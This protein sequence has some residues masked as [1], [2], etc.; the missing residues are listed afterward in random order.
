MSLQHITWFEPPP[1]SADVPSGLPDLFADDAFRQP[2]HPLAQRAAAM[3]IAELAPATLAALQQPGGGKMFGVLLVCDLSATPR[4]GFLRGFSGKLDGE[5]HA[6]GYVPPLFDEAARALWWTDG[7]AYLATLDAQLAALEASAAYID[8]A[9]TL[10]AALTAQTAELEQ[11]RAM[12]LARRNQRAEQRAATP[13]DATML[14]QLDAA[15]RRDGALQRETKQRLASAVQQARSALQPLTAEHTRLRELRSATSRRFMQTVY[16]EYDLRGVDNVRVLLRDCFAPHDPPGGAGD[17][18]APKMVGFANAHGLRSLA[19]A[20]FWIGSPPTHGGRVHGVFYPPCRGKCGAILPKMLPAPIATPIAMPITQVIAT[21]PLLESAAPAL[22]SLA[23]IPVLYRDDRLLIV[24]KPSGMLSIPGRGP[25]LADA[26]QTR[27]QQALNNPAAVVAHRLDQDT[28]G[29]IVVA[30]DAATL[31]AMHQLF[32][33]RD[34][35][36]HYIAEL[37]GTTA[38]LP[39]GASGTIHLPL[40]PDHYDRPRQIVDDELGKSAATEWCVLQVFANR[41]RVQLTP[42]TG[43][44]HQL[45]VHAAHPKGLALPIAG[46][47]IYGHGPTPAAPRLLLHAARL[48]FVHPWTGVVIELASPVPF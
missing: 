44:T 7:E 27:A 23:D 34:V 3:V 39:A 45:R 16:D 48:R 9:A 35:V 8:A 47:R 29:L 46:D 42:Q 14:Q 43:R 22:S 1:A 13:D 26:V 21:Q 38:A 28:S 36:K 17:C 20:E 15:S 24:H 12:L 37:D 4:V 2:I 5:W 41:T 30:L 11:L 33:R 18:A 6:P 25:R 32:A 40:R 19:L 10:Q 31:A